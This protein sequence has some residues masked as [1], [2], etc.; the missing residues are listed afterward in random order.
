MPV[1]FPMLKADF[2]H[3]AP[4][5]IAAIL[6]LL[7]VQHLLKTYIERKI[8]QIS[9]REHRKYEIAFEMMRHR[10][11]RATVGYEVWINKVFETNV[12]LFS[13]LS[14]VAQ[15]IRTIESE[16]TTLA[17]LKR[18]E[19][20]QYVSSTYGESE[21]LRK[22]MSFWHSNH[23][24]T[25][26]EMDRYLRPIR[27]ERS[28]VATRLLEQAFEANQLFLADEVLQSATEIMQQT[29]EYL[30]DGMAESTRKAGWFTDALAKIRGEI[31]RA[32][33]DDHVPMA[34]ALVTAASSLPRKTPLLS[35]FPRRKVPAAELT[36]SLTGR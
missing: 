14:T 5:T 4:L 30:A 23:D 28:R 20:E 18:E 33:S 27:L 24:D 31:I 8:D 34:Q 2:E 7:L 15:T 17:T 19:A 9:Q 35:L 36:N 11:Q 21:D 22:I 25:L 3:I 13:R 1:E 6:L 10:N 12:E 16:A 26:A 32:L 29:R